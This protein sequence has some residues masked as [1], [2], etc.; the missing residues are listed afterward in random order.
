VLLGQAVLVVWWDIDAGTEDDFNSWHLNEHVPER[1]GIRG[2]IRARRYVAVS[3]GPKFFTLY[4][5]ESAEVFGSQPYVERLNNPT[6][7][8]QNVMPHFRNMKRTA[9]HVVMTAGVVD[10]GSIATIELTPNQPSRN[11]FIEALTSNLLPSLLRLPGIAAVHLCQPVPSPIRS[12][13]KEQQLRVQPDATASWVILIEATSRLEIETALRVL[14]G[15][16]EFS[17]QTLVDTSSSI[18]QLSFALTKER[19]ASQ[20]ADI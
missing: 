10:G 15:D 5:T 3:G 6:P 4:E 17:S 13:T 12:P 8:T 16:R 18:Y 20:T 2:F 11:L 1:V 9:S 7:W 14:V 19:S